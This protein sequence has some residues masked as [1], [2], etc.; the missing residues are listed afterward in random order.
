M[1]YCS[2]AELRG[3]TLNATTVPR[4]YLIVTEYKKNILREMI[5][6]LPSALGR[7]PISDEKSRYA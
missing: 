6:L 3:A 7:M 4:T 1:L 2:V 5:V